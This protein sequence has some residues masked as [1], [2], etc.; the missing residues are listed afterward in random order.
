MFASAFSSLYLVSFGNVKANTG[1]E[2]RCLLVMMH[3]NCSFS[4]SIVVV[5]VSFYYF[6]FREI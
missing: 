4:V 2:F 3:T 6:I 5:D 1:F